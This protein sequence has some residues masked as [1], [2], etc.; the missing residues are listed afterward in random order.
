MSDTP[1]PAYFK[2]RKDNRIAGTLVTASL[3]LIADALAVIFGLNIAR[4]SLIYVAVLLAAAILSGLI[5][6]HNRIAIAVSKPLLLLLAGACIFAVSTHALTS[7]ASL[8]CCALGALLALAYVLVA[9]GEHW[10]A[11]CKDVQSGEDSTRTAI[12]SLQSKP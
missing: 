1:E 3:S 6:T 4:G 10:N 2:W 7:R 11:F 12:N 8:T 9:R 5:M